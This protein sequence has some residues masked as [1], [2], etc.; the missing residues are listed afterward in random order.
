MARDGQR[1]S[2]G[3]PGLDEILKGGLI[4]N[5][6]YLVRGGPGAGKTIL[7][8]SFL[9]ATAGGEDGT[10]YIS[11]GESEVN[12]RSN[13]SQLGIEIGGM[14]FLDLRPGP[15][16]FTRAEGYYDIF[17][18]VEV[19]RSPLT[20]RVI[21]AIER[22]RPNR[23]FIDPMTQLRYLARDSLQFRRQM[24]AF[25]DYL[26]SHGSTVLMSSETGL[27]TSD[28][29]LQFVSDGVISLESV[30]GSGM[31]SVIKFR[32][33][34]FQ[35]GRH[36]MRIT[37]RGLAAFPRLIPEEHARGFVAEQIP[38]GVAGIDAMLHGGLE[39]GTVTFISGPS[40]TGKTTLGLLFV[41]EAA[42]RGERSAVFTFDEDPEIIV[43]RSE[44][45]NIP[46]RS[47]MDAGRLSI[48]KV[49]PL[50]RSVDEFSG[51]VR[52]EVEE[53]H[54]K[55]VVIDSVSSFKLALRG[56]DLQ[57]HLH[58]LAS[59]L[60]NMGVLGVIVTE[61]EDIGVNLRLTEFKASYIADNIVF[62]RYMERRFAGGVEVRRLIGV[63][64]KRSSDHEKTVREYR[65]TPRGVEVGE[66]LK[67]STI[68][69]GPPIWE[70]TQG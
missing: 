38:S 5:R 39:R 47:M 15:E 52:R 62:L 43:G 14:E 33:S 65:I 55:V 16:F 42:A 69:Y 70:D 67:L 40:G 61:T 17:P 35:P 66:P 6:T 53:L 21:E 12:V 27:E 56:E 68:L 11:L 36:A 32:G 7:G 19:E 45:L 2:T 29:E 23:V 1:I 9:S 46:I 24:I 60:A 58:A 51:M 18:A 25:L 48:V 20:K 8:L 26:I 37:D 3:I 34:G 30:A 13:A 31:L 4:P 28:E 41:K 54:A 10:L 50:L 63:M 22:I 44:G 64:K 49:E 57:A 59:Y